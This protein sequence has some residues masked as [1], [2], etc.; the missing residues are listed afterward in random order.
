M[1]LNTIPCLHL[2]PLHLY[3]R[4]RFRSPPEYGMLATGESQL[5]LIGYP[6]PQ[7]HVQGI[8]ELFYPRQPQ[9]LPAH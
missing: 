5:H 7:L 2:H 6:Q 4:A 3:S 9:I 8:Q 1:S